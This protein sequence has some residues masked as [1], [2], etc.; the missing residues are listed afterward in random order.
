MPNGM[1]QYYLHA[2]SMID[3]CGVPIED[4]LKSNEAEEVHKAAQACIKDLQPDMR[5]KVED[6]CNEEGWAQISIRKGDGDE[7]LEI[8][9]ICFKGVADLYV[10]PHRLQRL[11]I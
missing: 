4:P 5:P 1:A 9:N 6:Y 10:D 8:C 2:E 11:V 7:I 3:E